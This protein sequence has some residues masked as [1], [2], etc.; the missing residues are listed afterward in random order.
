MLFEFHSKENAKKPGS[1]H[2]M[3][4]LSGGQPAKPSTEVNGN[5]GEDVHM[6][7]SPFFSSSMPDRDDEH[8]T[9]EPVTRVVTLVREEQLEGISTTLLANPVKSGCRAHILYRGQ[10]SVHGALLHSY[11]QPEPETHRGLLLFTPMTPSD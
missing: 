2:A 9:V 5:D 3:Y 6:Q 10:S 7:S 4:L 1:V 11:L 8:D